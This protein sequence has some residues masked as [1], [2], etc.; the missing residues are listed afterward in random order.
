MRQI[1]KDLVHTQPHTLMYTHSRLNYDV[2]DFPLSLSKL[3]RFSDAHFL[4]KHSGQT[5]FVQYILYVYPKSVRA[6]VHVQ[7]Q[8][9]RER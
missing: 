4:A 7:E 9:K 2:V 5:Q 8:N 6:C 3:R 1:I